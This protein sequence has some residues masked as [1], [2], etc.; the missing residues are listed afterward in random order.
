ML[1]LSGGDILA[2]PHGDR[3]KDILRAHQTLPIN[4]LYVSGPKIADSSNRW[5]PM[6]PGRN[7]MSSRYGNMRVKEDGLFINKSDASF[8]GLLVDHSTA[9]F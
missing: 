7:F 3:M 6:Y 5:T 8:F 4:L 1:G 9:R 2:L